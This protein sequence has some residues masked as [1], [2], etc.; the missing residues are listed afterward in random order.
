[1]RLEVY[2]PL[3]HCPESSYRTVRTAMAKRDSV[4]R[5]VCRGWLR[6]RETGKFLELT[7]YP[8]YLAC[9]N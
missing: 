2:S 3:F 8:V 5:S 1:M 9:L 6:S 7:R 4:T